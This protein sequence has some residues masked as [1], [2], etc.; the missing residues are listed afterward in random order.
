EDLGIR[1]LGHLAVN[2]GVRTVADDIKTLWRALSLQA[3]DHPDRQLAFAKA[4]A[5][6]INVVKGDAHYKNHRHFVTLQGPNPSPLAALK[7]SRVWLESVADEVFLV[8]NVE[9]LPKILEKALLR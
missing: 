5:M 4:T 1:K 8:E 7:D 3:Y 2:V 6:D 9:A